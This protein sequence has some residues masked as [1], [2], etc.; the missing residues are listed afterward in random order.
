MISIGYGCKYM[1]FPQF[2]QVYLW[3]NEKNFT[4]IF[5]VLLKTLAE[6]K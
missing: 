3:I 2:L 6:L 1:F 5:V 4:F